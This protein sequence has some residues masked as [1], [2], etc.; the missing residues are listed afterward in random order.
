VVLGLRDGT[1]YLFRVRGVDDALRGTW[2]TKLR[3][4]VP[5]VGPVRDVVLRRRSAEVR[6]HG[7]AVRYATSY[8]VRAAGAPGCRRSPAAS[9]FSLVAARLPRPRHRF[10]PT[11]AAPALWVRWYAVHDGVRGRSVRSSLACLRR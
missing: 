11:Q 7:T 3:A 9:R 5:L 10:V 4:T 8:Q 2:S 6:T 1:T